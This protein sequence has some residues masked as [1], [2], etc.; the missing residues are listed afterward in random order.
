MEIVEKYRVADT[1]PKMPLFDFPKHSQTYNDNLKKVFQ[2][3][4]LDRT[5]VVYN[6]YDEA[7]FKP[8]YELAMSKFARSSF[9]DTL[10]GQGV[11]DNIICTMSGHTAGSKAFH[12]Y[13]NSMKN[14]QQSA[15]VALLD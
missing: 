1:H 6:A 2:K 8:L 3:A 7:E 15:A 13:H 10:V 14:K 4:G 5:V 11:T 9:I 12:R